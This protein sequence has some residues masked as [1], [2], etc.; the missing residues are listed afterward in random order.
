M[1]D[2]YLK[3]AA[4]PL[5]F[6]TVTPRT[7]GQNQKSTMPNLARVNEDVDEPSFFGQFPNPDPEDISPRDQPN[8]FVY[9]LQ[10]NRKV[11]HTYSAKMKRQVFFDALSLDA[12]ALFLGEPV[13]PKVLDA[14]EVII[15]H[16]NGVVIKL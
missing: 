10:H 8:Q 11:S 13:P 15:F 3:L 14:T 16:C 5:G 1:L 7:K 9:L 12:Q 2:T 4:H 6:Q